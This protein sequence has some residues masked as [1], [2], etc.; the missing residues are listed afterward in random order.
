MIDQITTTS[1]VN[2]GEQEKEWIAL[3]SQFVLI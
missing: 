2:L 1:S 3:P